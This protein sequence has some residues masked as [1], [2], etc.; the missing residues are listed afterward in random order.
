MK[1][2]V[3]WSPELKLGVKRRGVLNGQFPGPVV[4][5]WNKDIGV[6]DRSLNISFN[7]TKKTLL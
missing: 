7:D 4:F 1:V 6:R 3:T 2:R 5:K